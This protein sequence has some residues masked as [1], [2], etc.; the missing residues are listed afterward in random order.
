MHHSRLSDFREI[1]DLNNDMLLT[2]AVRKTIIEGLRINCLIGIF[3]EERIAPQPV[4][5][6]VELIVDED[7][8]VNA[9][10]S[11]VIRYDKVVEEVE[12]IALCGHIDLVE[13]LAELIVTYCERFPRI[14]SIRV[15][16]RKLEAIVNANSVG[17]ELFRVYKAPEAAAFGVV[18]ST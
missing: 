4:E 10:L 8:N 1:T 18:S 15:N 14:R 13:T 3:P 9:D 7:C 12:K 16:I 6:D 11:K 2:H 17:V 5:I